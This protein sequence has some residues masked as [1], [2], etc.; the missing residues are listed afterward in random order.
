MKRAIVLVVLLAGCKGKGH[1]FHPPDRDKQAA[2]AASQYSPQ[3]FDSVKWTNKAEQVAA[4]NEV[5]ARECDKCHGMLG[6]AGTAYAQEHELKVP[7]LVDPNW[8]YAND[9]EGARKKIFTGHR[10]MPTWGVA[11]L[12][13]REIDAV[14]AYVLDQLR[15]DALKR[16]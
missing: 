7:P 4:G 15:P 14:A 9:R 12:S 16:P 1:V 6:E 5:Y 13:P 2:E 8:K 11:R 10:D 3:L